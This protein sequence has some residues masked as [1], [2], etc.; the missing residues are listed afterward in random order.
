MRVLVFLFACTLC[1]GVIG[2]AAHPPA[3]LVNPI[4]KEP[5]PYGP[6]PEVVDHVPNPNS[7]EADKRRG[8]VAKRYLRARALG[9]A[10]ED[11]HGDH[12]FLEE[13]G[14]ELTHGRAPGIPK[15]ESESESESDPDLSPTLGRMD[16]W[17][18]LGS[19]A[20]FAVSVSAWVSRLR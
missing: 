17:L 12:A 16:W 6:D 5:S 8:V 3:P 9:N 10:D 19:T 13:H 2:V 20:M 15:C 14:H 7:T 11:P 1:C 18:L 4:T